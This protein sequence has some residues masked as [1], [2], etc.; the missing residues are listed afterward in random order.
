MD[1][2]SQIKSEQ[3]RLAQ[4]VERFVAEMPPQYTEAEGG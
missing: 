1:K 2:T 4:D 3:I